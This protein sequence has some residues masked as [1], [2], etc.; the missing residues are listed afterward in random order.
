MKEM[1]ERSVICRACRRCVTPDGGDCPA[2][3]AKIDV[4]ENDFQD[5]EFE[6]ITDGY[7]SWYSQPTAYHRI[8][9]CRN[10]RESCGQCLHNADAF[11]RNGKVD[12]RDPVEQD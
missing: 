7:H 9:R 3:G 1:K 2:C 12:L 5:L 6:C 8:Y 4:P 11:C 10:Y